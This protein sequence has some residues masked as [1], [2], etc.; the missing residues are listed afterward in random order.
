MMMITSLAGGSATGAELFVELCDGTRSFFIRT[1]SNVGVQD[2]CLPQHLEAS[3]DNAKQDQEWA[4]GREGDDPEMDFCKPPRSVSVRE[5]PKEWHDRE[6][7]ITCA[8]NRMSEH[9]F[10]RGR[11]RQ[12]IVRE[13]VVECKRNAS[14]QTPNSRGVGP[15]FRHSL[16]T[17][18]GSHE[19]DFEGI[20][21]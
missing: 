2:D 9:V 7:D 17:G 8:G 13:P 1:S 3:G 10:P 5:R 19:T 14:D 20:A 21:A 16:G 18:V 12:V 11:D 15:N 6:C 4:D